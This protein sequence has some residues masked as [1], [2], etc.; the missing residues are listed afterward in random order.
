MGNK[1]GGGS[2]HLRNRIELKSACY[3]LKKVEELQKQK[4]E[5]YS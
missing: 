4:L 3:P 5:E 1:S 2:G